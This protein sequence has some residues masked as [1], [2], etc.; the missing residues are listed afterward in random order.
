MVEAEVAEPTLVRIMLQAG[1]DYWQMTQAIAE[2]L[3]NLSVHAHGGESHELF[4]RGGGKHAEVLDSWESTSEYLALVDE[5]LVAVSEYQ[6]QQRAAG[7]DGAG[8]PAIERRAIEYSLADGCE[9]LTPGDVIQPLIPVTPEP[10]SYWDAH[11]A[12]NEMRSAS[13]QNIARNDDDPMNRLLALE[14]G[15]FG[16]TR[17]AVQVYDE[18]AG[19]LDEDIV[20]RRVANQRN[21]LVSRIETAEYNSILTVGQ[22]A[23]PFSL[24]DLAGTDVSLGSVLAENQT[25]FVDFWASWCGPCI[26]AFP[27]LKELYSTYGDDGFEIVGISIDSNVEDWEEATIEH[28]IPWL[29]LGEIGKDPQA[30]ESVSTIY[31]AISIPKGYVLD[32]QG[33]VIGKDVFPDRLKEFLD[34]RY[35]ESAAEPSGDYDSATSGFDARSMGMGS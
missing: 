7:Q 17:D 12:R 30:S 35:G 34:D 5:Y 32:R 29:N 15:A 13:L 27:E 1:R 28:E 2:P 33:C 4:A 21:Q 6:A 3:A 14:L 19:Q 8:R 22:Q 20:A 10:P 26:A 23:P 11:L 24:P 18:I 9:H 31:G 25:V 16:Q